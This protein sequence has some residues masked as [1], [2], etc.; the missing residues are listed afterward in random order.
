M[1]HYTSPYIYGLNTDPSACPFFECIFTEIG[2][3]PSKTKIIVG[4]FNVVL[5]TDND[6]FYGNA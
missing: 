1:L 4:S 5:D 6:K 2:K 3:L